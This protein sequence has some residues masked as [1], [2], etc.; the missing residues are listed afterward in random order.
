[1]FRA[2]V[3]QPITVAFRSANQRSNFFGTGWLISAE[4]CR[5]RPDQ[6]FFSFG[7][8]LGDV[9]GLACLD[10]VFEPRVDDSGR[11]RCPISDP[12]RQLDSCCANLEIGMQ[13]VQRGR[14]KRNSLF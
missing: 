13:I 5:L 2:K 4:M 14:R 12:I 7:V 8:S 9:G 11:T 6:I 1:M 10:T 3:R